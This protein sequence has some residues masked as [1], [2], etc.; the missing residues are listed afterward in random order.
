M[1]NAPPSLFWQRAEAPAAVPLLLWLS[2]ARAREKPRRKSREIAGVNGRE[3][4]RKKPP[5]ICETDVGVIPIFFSNV[6]V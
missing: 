3:T 2:R 6:N 4:E 1:D 5:V